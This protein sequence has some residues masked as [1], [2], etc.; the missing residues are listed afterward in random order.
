MAKHSTK[1]DIISI[2][3]ATLDTF[4]RVSEASVLCDV[5]REACLLCFNYA[6]KIP[7]E[8]LD[9]TAAGNAANNAVG[10]SRLGMKAAFYS[11]I[12]DDEIGHLIYSTMRV[13]RV[14]TDYLQVDPKNESNYSVVL[15]YKGERTIL[16][17][18]APRVYRL[19][20]MAPSKWVYY[21]EIG[22]NHEKLE[23]RILAY[24]KKTNAKLAYNPGT[25]QIREG[26]ER[27]KRILIETEVLF[28]NK[29]EAEKLAGRL[30]GIPAL[31]AALREYGPKIVVITDGPRGAYVYDGRHT[32]S[33]GVF[34]V[35]VVEMT[36]AGDAFATGFITAL[37]YGKPVYEALRWGS[38][39]STGVIM[40]IGPQAGLLTRIG[41]QKM[42]K[43]FARI[44][45][46]EMR[47]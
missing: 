45:A 43:R 20:E 15:S 41:M 21:T 4:V 18:H 35:K 40:Q 47:V 42:L 28:V 37:H 46:T 32:H 9:R 19:P 17:Y 3:D 36:G 14:A 5:N 44:K 31:A 23:T 7:I 10:S 39:N 38:A 16:V 33:I 30:G 6:D 12:G 25:G 22:E 29:Q 8:R 2:G 34:P 24:I 11:V 26:I 13:E 1:F 27:M